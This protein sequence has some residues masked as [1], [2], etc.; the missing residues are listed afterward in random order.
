MKT[1][2]VVVVL[3]R[4]GAANAGVELDACLGDS[5]DAI[6]RAVI[7]ELGDA[8]AVHASIACDGP[9][10]V[11][12][13]DDPS[14]GAPVRRRLDLG[15]AMGPMGPRLIALALVEL[16]ADTRSAAPPHAIELTDEAPPPSPLVAR[17][18]RAWPGT[19]AAV[20]AGGVWFT[21]DPRTLTGLGLKVATASRI[22]G[23]LDAQ[24]HHRARTINIGDVTTDLLGFGAAAIVHLGTERTSVDAGAGIRGGGVRMSGSPMTPLAHG[25]VFWSKWAGVFATGALS[26]AINSQVALDGAV[27]LGQVVVPVIGLV[28]RKPVTTIDGG[29]LAVHLGIVVQ[30]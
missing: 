1:L 29:W 19:R 27:E 7:V 21:A 9:V 14:T 25:G 4:A 15:L 28:D 16:V 20:G 13:V 11:L 22:G 18:E 26:I 8:P 17:S 5:R 3:L 2:L 10:V 12:S 23:M 24:Y 30:L 6:Q